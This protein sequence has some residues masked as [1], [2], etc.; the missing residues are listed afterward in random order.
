M[1]SALRILQD[2]ASLSFL[3]AGIGGLI[4]L[5]RQ[6]PKDQHGSVEV[7]VAGAGFWCLT[8]GSVLQLVVSASSLAIEKLPWILGPDTVL[9]P[10]IAP[11]GIFLW[12][13]G[14]VLLARSV[15]ISTRRHIIQG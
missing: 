15:V 6:V 8:V 10:W 2:L 14:L 3:L 7:S 9:P 11:A 1:I 5:H 12:S 4:L 13:L